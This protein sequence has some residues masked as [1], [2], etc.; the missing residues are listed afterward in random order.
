M[1]N[2]E[3]QVLEVTLLKYQRPDQGV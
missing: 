3:M 1:N 2:A